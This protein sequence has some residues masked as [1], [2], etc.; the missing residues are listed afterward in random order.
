MKEFQLAESFL[1]EFFNYEHY[2]NAIQKARAAI[3][4]KNEYQEKWQ[5][6]S[7]AIKERNF[8]PREPLSLVNHAANQVLDENSDNEAYVW[9]DK[10]VYNLEMQDV[11]VDE[12]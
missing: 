3:I 6:I 10:L 9:L 5:K 1:R 4:S 12:Y 7:I 2:S 11:K 8:Q